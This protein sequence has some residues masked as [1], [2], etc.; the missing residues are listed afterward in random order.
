[1]KIYSLLSTLY[2]LL[3]IYMK[4]PRR[5]APSQF[6]IAMEKGDYRLP[7]ELPTKWTIF[8]VIKTYLIFR[9]VLNYPGDEEIDWMTALIRNEGDV[10]KAGREVGMKKFTLYKKI[11]RLDK[12]Y[13]AKRALLF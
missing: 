10:E 7:S 4:K 6:E 13:Q 12:T 3:F 1:M 2:L 11:E 9:R 8:D 5:E